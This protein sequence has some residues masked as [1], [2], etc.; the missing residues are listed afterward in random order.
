MKPFRSLVGSLMYLACGTRPDI[1]V[2]VSHFLGNPG[3]KHWDVGIRVV[4]YLR[5][6]KNLGIMYKGSLGTD[7]VAYS[8]TDWAGNRDERRSVSGIVLMMCGAPV[9]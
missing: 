8:D 5:K 7:L 6:T 9:V 2:A 3:E 1:S 4:R